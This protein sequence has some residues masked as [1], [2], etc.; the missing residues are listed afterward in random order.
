MTAFQGASE[1]MKL[2]E[3]FTRVS[4]DTL[5]YR[6]TVD[7]PDDVDAAVDGG[8]AVEEGDRPDLRAR[9]PRGQLRPHQH[10]SRARAPKRSEP[11]KRPKKNSK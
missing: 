9:V 8:S 5:T 7:D 4:D 1:D 6:F 10:C 2:T 11:P 3:R